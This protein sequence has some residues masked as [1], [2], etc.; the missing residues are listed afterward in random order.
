MVLRTVL[1]CCALACGAALL[2]TAVNV[3]LLRRP[4]ARPRPVTGPVDVLVPARDEAERIAPC[5]RSLL[6]QRDVPG[7]RITVLDDGSTDGT[8]GVVRAVAGDDS[9]LR[10]VT[11]APPP[12]GWLGKPHACQRLADA[13]DAPVMI[14]VDADVVCAPHA[15]AAGVALLDAARADLVS[16]YPAIVA[17][18]AQRL[19]QPLVRWSWLTFLPVRAVERSHRPSLAAACGQFLV[20]RRSGYAAAGGHAAVRDRVLEDVELA[21]A[22][23]RAGGRT[24]LADGAPLATCRMYGSWREL[25][26]GY[27]KSL[28]AS[29]GSPAGAAAVL[30][31]LAAV[32][33]LPPAG[34]L[35]GWVAGPAAGVAGLAGYLAAV[36]GRWLTDRRWPDP[37]AHPVSIALL[38][39]LVVRSYRRRDRATWKGRPVRVPPAGMEGAR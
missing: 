20:V 8:A 30:S 26:D 27:T 22:V 11:G 15:V 16:P 34:A 5:L 17:T 21:R 29:F 14:F 13:T 4:P 36:A 28:W 32:Y 10:L 31:L 12:P 23:K 35:L 3:A 1:L 9:R 6:A 19:V 25:V 39:W 24:A 37:L 38:G 18:G 7:L 2:H 33:L